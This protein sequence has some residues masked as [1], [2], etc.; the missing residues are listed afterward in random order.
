V[1]SNQSIIHHHPSAAITA[2]V[3]WTQAK[4]EPRIQPVGPESHMFSSVMCSLTKAVPSEE[5][6]A[7]LE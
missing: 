7:C 3:T 2:A 1:A 6:Y 5:E 4:E